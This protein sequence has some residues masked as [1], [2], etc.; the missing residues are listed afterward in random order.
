MKLL[1]DE[2]KISILQQIFTYRNIYEMNIILTLGL[3]FMIH[4][5]MIE[6]NK[7]IYK[8]DQTGI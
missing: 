7:F 3:V 2:S 8:S 6:P 1:A 4:V 5:K